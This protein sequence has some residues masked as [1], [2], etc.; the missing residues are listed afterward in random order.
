MTNAAI[1]KMAETNNSEE[2]EKVSKLDSTEG[3]SYLDNLA[4]LEAALAEV[5]EV[6]GEEA[7]PVDEP[8]DSS[9]AP[10][11]PDFSA[12]SFDRQPSAPKMDE[13]TSS[14]MPSSVALVP[15]NEATIEF[16]S[17]LLGGALGFAVGGPV[18]AAIVAAATNY[19]SKNDEGEVSEIV[20]TVSKST[21]Q[22]YNYFA[23]LD[24]KYEVVDG[25]RKNLQNTLDDLKNNEKID[26]KVIEQTEKALEATKA[27]LDDLNKE[28]DFVNAGSVAFGVV[29]DLVEKAVNTIGDF[30]S[31]YGLTDR[32]KNSIKDVVAKSKPTKSD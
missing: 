29:G 23:K 8:A 5:K 30:N 16:T 1:V 24:A 25:A 2:T 18:L 26:P 7:I 27:R 9:T 32:A 12:S 14:T 19:V 13:S 4:S 31:E 17:G 3:S 11:V 28:Y 6:V 22:V 15:V 21:I 20:Q 10:S